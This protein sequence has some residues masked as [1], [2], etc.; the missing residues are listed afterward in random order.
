MGFLKE[1]MV[2]NLPEIAFNTHHTQTLLFAS[3]FHI[4]F[5]SSS[6]FGS[7]ILE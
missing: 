5:G 4:Y 2:F 1:L 3:P 6:N 7:S